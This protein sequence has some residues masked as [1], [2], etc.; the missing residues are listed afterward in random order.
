MRI[1][2]E[3]QLANGNVA[4]YQTLKRCLAQTFDQFEYQKHDLKA[5]TNT[6]NQIG[7]A[8]ILMSFP[9]APGRKAS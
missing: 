4:L 6:V 7:Q 2:G 1:R 5:T 8:L 3:S 9:G